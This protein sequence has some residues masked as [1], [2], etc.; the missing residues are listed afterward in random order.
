M[1]MYNYVHACLYIYRVPVV[2][3]DS[4]RFENNFMNREAV[5]SGSVPLRFV[6]RPVHGFIR[7]HSVRFFSVFDCVMAFYKGSVCGNIDSSIKTIMHWRRN[8]LKAMAFK[9]AETEKYGKLVLPNSFGF[10]NLC[11]NGK[12]EQIL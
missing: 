6:S 10:E 1:Y 11:C 2:R 3:I 9:I 8:F 5:R 7:F 12:I 4:H